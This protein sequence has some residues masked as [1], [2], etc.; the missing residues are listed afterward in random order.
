MTSTAAELALELLQFFDVHPRCQGSFALTEDGHY[1]T[2]GSEEARYFCAEAA[3]ARMQASQ[4]VRAALSNKAW[5]VFKMVTI[6]LND[7]LDDGEFA[8][9]L[10]FLACITEEAF[11]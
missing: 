5:A 6:E 7:E 11:E 4:E 3:G 10:A 9:A 1:T 8:V 2:N